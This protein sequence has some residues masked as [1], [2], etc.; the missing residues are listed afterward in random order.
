MRTIT[1]QPL[2]FG[3]TE[4]YP[5]HIDKRGNVERQDFWKGNPKSLIGFCYRPKAGEINLDLKDFLADPLK[6]VNLFPVFEKA[7]GSWY[8]L[9]TIIESVTVHDTKKERKPKK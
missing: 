8:T 1:L 6:A 5:Y 2:G 4:P 9:K 3:G 7:D